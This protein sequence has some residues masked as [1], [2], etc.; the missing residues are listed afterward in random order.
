MSKSM[1]AAAGPFPLYGMD[2]CQVPTT[3]LPKV[4]HGSALSVW[5]SLSLIKLHATQM[6]DEP[7]NPIGAYSPLNV[8]SSSS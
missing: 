4:N 8:D 1:T 7:I 5:T 3:R 6:A 2:D